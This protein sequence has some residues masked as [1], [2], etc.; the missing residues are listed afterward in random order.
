MERFRSSEKGFT[1]I[2]LL[3]VVA[4]IGILAAIAIPQFTK[5]KKNASKSACNA[6]LKICVSEAAAKF[7]HNGT[8]GEDCSSVGGSPFVNTQLI[9]ATAP[10]F[11]V[12]T[13]N[14]IVYISGNASGITT[15]FFQKAFGYPD[16]VIYSP[17]EDSEEGRL[18]CLL[19]T[20]QE[21]DNFENKYPE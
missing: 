3:I 14:G 4:I 8:N 19:D 20:D 13:E 9:G 10:S 12:N 15:D 18:E 6:D 21:P 1:L 5:Y 2:E 7:A 16:L 17:G 11:T